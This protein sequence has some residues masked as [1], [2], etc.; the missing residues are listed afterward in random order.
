MINFFDIFKEHRGLLNHF[1]HIGNQIV[2]EKVKK[3]IYSLLAIS[4]VGRVGDC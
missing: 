2:F 4:S 3:E 1:D